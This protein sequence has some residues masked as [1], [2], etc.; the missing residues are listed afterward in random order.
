MPKGWILCPLYPHQS[1]FFTAH[2]SFSSHWGISHPYCAGPLE[3][4]RLV[5]F[6][7]FA[8]AAYIPLRVRGYPLP[9]LDLSNFRSHPPPSPPLV[10]QQLRSGVTTHIGARLV[11][12]CVR[13]E[14]FPSLDPLGDSLQGLDG[15]PVSLC[16]RAWRRSNS[17][18]PAF[19][20][21]RMTRSN[22]LLRFGAPPPRSA[23]NLA[24]F[25]GPHLSMHVAS[26]AADRWTPST[27]STTLS[28]RQ[29]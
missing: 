5:L 12:R 3:A 9:R 10:D 1:E 26:H 17:R 18:T 22:T 27:V 13:Q 8:P 20:P 24:A 14:N 28:R 25:I 23:L 16:L 2:L 7:F 6:A 11:Q 29:G 19:A 15:G 21:H 4:N